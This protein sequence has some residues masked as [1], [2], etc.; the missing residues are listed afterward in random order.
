MI[1][2]EI[3]VIPCDSGPFLPGIL[4]AGLVSLRGFAH[5]LNQAPGPVVLHEHHAKRTTRRGDSLLLEHWKENVF[6]LAVMALIHE[7]A[8]E[9]HHF[10]E[11]FGRHRFSAAHLARHSFGEVEHGSNG[12]VFLPQ[13][14]SCR[15]H[16]LTPPPGVSCISKSK[17]AMT[18]VTAMIP[19]SNLSCHA[20][21]T[22]TS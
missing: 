18:K 14:A 3:R 22:A 9:I 2:H 5:S 12:L 4:T 19:A 8:D 17:T 7:H 13:N 20:C 21:G 1:M 10:C 6:L 15:S 11:H 16:F